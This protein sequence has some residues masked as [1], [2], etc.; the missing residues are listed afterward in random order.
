MGTAI[1]QTLQAIAEGPRSQDLA[2][3]Y[4]RIGRQLADVGRQDADASHV[5]QIV[6]ECAEAA[7]EATPRRDEATQ[8]A[9]KEALS[10]LHR[11]GLRADEQQ[12][13]N[14]VSTQV[15]HLLAK[16]RRGRN[17]KHARKLKLTWWSSR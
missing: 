5:T 1:S 17:K 14:A 15:N 16:S 4:S 7:V 2:T 9:T 6:Q 12:V 11:D 10:R 8:L 13:W 3:F